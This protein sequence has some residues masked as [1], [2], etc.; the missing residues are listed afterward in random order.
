MPGGQKRTLDSLDLLGP[1][2]ALN[3]MGPLHSLHP[4]D[5]EL[6][7]MSHHVGIRN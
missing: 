6:E 4:L 5:P 1:L 7:V 3:P 2:H